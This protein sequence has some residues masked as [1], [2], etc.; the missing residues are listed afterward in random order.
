[1]KDRYWFHQLNKRHEK[2]V[3][4]E[5]VFYAVREKVLDN[6]PE[7]LKVKLFG[8]YERQEQE[9]LL[10]RICVEQQPRWKLAKATVFFRHHQQVRWYW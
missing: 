1:M 9:K 6:W 2:P 3:R 5:V 4:S 8:S 7:G 10:E